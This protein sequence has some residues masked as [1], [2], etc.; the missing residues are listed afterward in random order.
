MVLGKMR[1]LIAIHAHAPAGTVY[2]DLLFCTLSIHHWIIY[3]RFHEIEIGILHSKTVRQSNPDGDH[4]I[5]RDSAVAL[6]AERMGGRNFL[7]SCL[8][9]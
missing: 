9:Q 8:T 4:I 7:I 2:L 5:F 1:Y 3:V 6:Y